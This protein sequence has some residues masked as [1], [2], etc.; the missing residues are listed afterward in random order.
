MCD[1]GHA[2]SEWTSGWFWL[3]PVNSFSGGTGRVGV[4]VLDGHVYTH[5]LKHSELIGNYRALK[6]RAAT[7]TAL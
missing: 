2:G 7:T 5:A 6:A 4:A 3:P 1:G